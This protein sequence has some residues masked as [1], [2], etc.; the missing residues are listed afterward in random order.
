MSVAESEF[1]TWVLEM[2]A[3]QGW[4]TVHG[5]DIAPGMLDAERSDY[6]EVVL[7]GRLRDAIYRLNPNLPDDAVEE[8]IKTAVRPESSVIQSEN[9]RAY[10][11]LTQGVPVE[12]RDAEGVLRNVRARLVDWAEPLSNDLI[13]VNQFTVQ[14]PKKER[15]PDVVLFV[16][17]LPLGLLELKKPGAQN[18]TI[19]SAYAQIQ[20]Y[21]AQIPD[22]FTWNAGVVISDGLLARMGTLTAQA[23]HYQAWKTIDG[24]NLATKYRPEIEVIVAGFLNPEVFLDWTR[25]FLAYS[26]DGAKIT[27]IGAKYHQYWAVR[28]AVHETIEAVETDGRAGIVW[29]TQGSG[30]S[31]EMA[32]TAGAL[33]RH[34]A[35][36]NPTLLVLTDRNDLD[37][38]L[39]EDTFAATKIGA[40]LPEAPVQAETRAE[41]KNLLSGRQSGGIVFTT[42][43]K[44]GLSKDERDAGIAFPTLSERMNIVVMVDE[45]HRSNYDF[46]DGF[47]RHLRDGLPNATFIGFTGTPIEAKDRSTTAVFGDVIDTY[48]LTQAVED[49]ATVKVLYEA[50]LAKV[51]LPEDA[52]TQIDNA[53]TEAVSGSED[54]AQDRLKSRWSRV[55][56]IVGSDERLT[57]LAADIVAHWDKRKEVIPEAKCMIVTMSRRIAVDLHDKIAAL[58]P[59]WATDDDA[60][61][62]MKVV[63]TGSATDPEHWQDHIRNKAQ[64]R[65][66]KARASDPEDPLDVVIV[67]DMWLTGFDSPAMT[68]MYVDKP[69]RGVSLMQA[70][71]R[72]N[73]T[74]R[75]KAAGLI[76]DY[77][78]IAEDLKTALGDYTQR[79][80]DNAQVG[81]DIEATAIPEMENEHDIVCSILSGFEWRP[82]VA[83]K[84]QKA[85]INAV[86]ATVEWLLEQEHVEDAFEGLD[87]DEPERRKELT[88]KQ[89]FIAHVARLRSFFSLVPASDA[90]TAIRD[91]VAFFDAVRAAIAKIEGAGR[92]ATDAG[93]ELDT[94]IRQIVSE[95]MTGTGVVDIYAEAGIA[96]PDISLID[97]AFVKKISES[98]RPNIQMEALKR[99]LNAE[100][101]AIAGRNLVKGKQFSE[102]L[103]ASLLRYQNRS[104]D[105]A[106]VV[107]E[108][109]RLAQALKAEQE[110][111]RE[112]GLTE[113]ELAFYDAL[114][115]NESAREAMQDETL[116]EIAH[117][118]TDIVRRDAKTDWSVKEQ[119][120]AKLR[121]TIKR[122]LLKHGYPPDKTNAAT[123]LILKQAETLSGQSDR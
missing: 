82:L 100:I 44:F 74:F 120:R 98:D 111:G 95:N 6:R 70:I 96:N 112:T 17:G 113:N 119:V 55:E 18:A 10:E 39:F 13:A 81:A 66:L 60:T 94:A 64:M 87:G 25:N 65:A 108:L 62:R 24:R 37:N 14:G 56:A 50:R 32:W 61:G 59:D 85:Y 104:L 84:T 28:K 89:R 46:I 107:A 79:D 20:T 86:M 23:N 53:F 52:L 93:A 15:R 43:Q 38:Q 77:I 80:R 57:E 69:M 72:V 45:A 3:E 51:R 47:A 92:G 7:E 48:D 41:L 91:D 5:P 97:D 33:M 19:A 35:M 63:M 116:K 58:R 49:G 123:E 8:A 103:N 54:E 12:Y 36:D 9:W 68:T 117:E 105:T 122:L 16:N 83:Q 76:V 42:I 101:R 21:K 11:L 115:D 73:R 30:K 29:H 78:G 88:V 102:M 75:D 40:P 90:A 67:R 2:L 31:F 118:L 1:E 110:R 114:R 27:K 106:A 4:Q 109:V 71:T 34:P 121:T 26:G 99:L 22:L